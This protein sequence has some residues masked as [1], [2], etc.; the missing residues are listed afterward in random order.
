[1]TAATRTVS[2]SV[3]AILISLPSKG[4]GISAFTL[5]V[6]TSTRGSSRLTKSPSCLSHLST[7]PSV[8]D[9]PSCGILTW[10]TPIFEIE[11]SSGLDGPYHPSVSSE[12]PPPPPPPQASTPPP[13]PLPP[14]PPAA[15]AYAVAPTDGMA[16]AALVIR[17]IS[18]VGL[19][20]SG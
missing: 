6:T 4:E 9:S 11:C 8:T 12:P 3:A 16:I 17:I 1:M 5:S 13:P 15:Y 10:A 7:V 14:P 19:F 20:C 2:P 18:A